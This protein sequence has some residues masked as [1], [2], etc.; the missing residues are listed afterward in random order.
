MSVLKIYYNY[1]CTGCLK[2]TLYVTINQLKHINTEEWGWILDSDWSDGLIFTQWSTHTDYSELVLVCY[3]FYSNNSN[4]LSATL[5]FLS[6]CATVDHPDPYSHSV[7]DTTLLNL[8]E[9]GYWEC[10]HW[11]YW[12]LA[13]GRHCLVQTQNLGLFTGRK[14]NPGRSSESAETKPLKTVG[15]IWWC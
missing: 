5:Y 3:C 15:K 11:E 10:W 8:S 13:L 1:Q 7:L 2:T 9:L 6:S 4:N 14:S 12:V